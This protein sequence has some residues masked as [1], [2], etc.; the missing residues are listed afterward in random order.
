MREVGEENEGEGA[1]Q[2]IELLCVENSRCCP[3]NP[4]DTNGGGEHLE[5][6][7]VKHVHDESQH[8]SRNNKM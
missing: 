7:G 1:S 5:N 4:V 2:V 6:V 8:F 3:S